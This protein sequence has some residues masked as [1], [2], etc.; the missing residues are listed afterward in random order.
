MVVLNIP[1]IRR[2]SFLLFEVSPPRD[3][4]VNPEFLLEYLHPSHPPASLSGTETSG[5][6]EAW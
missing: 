2:V 1:I 3:W 4:T 6:G 5:G